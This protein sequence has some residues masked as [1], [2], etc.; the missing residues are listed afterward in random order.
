MDD[1]SILNKLK[2]SVNSQVKLHLRGGD[3]FEGRLNHVGK[4]AI[5]KGWFVILDYGMIK[6]FDVS[7]IVSVQKVRPNAVI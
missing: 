1:P 6:T 7:D 5:K 4:S 2:D 3:S